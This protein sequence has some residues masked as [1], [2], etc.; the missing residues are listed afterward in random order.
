MTPLLPVLS[1]KDMV[2]IL[3]SKGFVKAG[4]KGSH[5]KMRKMTGNKVLTVIVPMHNELA[6]GT[7]KSILRQSG[8]SIKDLFKE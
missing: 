2:K 6:P 8:L 5:V 1:G 7:L 4:Q 3:R